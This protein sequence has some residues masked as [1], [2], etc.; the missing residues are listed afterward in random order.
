MGGSMTVVGSRVTASEGST[1]PTSDAPSWE[2]VPAVLWGPNEDTRLLLRGLL[3]LHRCTVVHEVASL[4]ELLALPPQPAPTI[5]VVDAET[6]DAE[7][8]RDLPAAIAQ[9]PELRALVVLPAGGG[10]SESR[11]RAAGASNVVARP[12]AIRDFVRAVEATVQRPPPSAPA[13]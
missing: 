8:D 13:P 7:W 11:A 1:G 3:R 9:H 5:L 2:G 4:G 10:F 6:D 12:F